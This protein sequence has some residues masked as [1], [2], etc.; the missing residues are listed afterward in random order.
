E[1]LKLQNKLLSNEEKDFNKEEVNENV[2]QTKDSGID[3]VTYSPLFQFSENSDFLSQVESFSENL[4]NSNVN[5]FNDYTSFVT[6]IEKFNKKDDENLIEKI[7]I[8]SEVDKNLLKL[9]IDL[10]NLNFLS[11]LKHKNFLDLVNYLIIS[12]KTTTSYSKDLEDKI[13]IILVQFMFEL[14][15]LN[16]PPRRIHESLILLIKNFNTKFVTNFLIPLIELYNSFDKKFPVTNSTDSKELQSNNIIL[17]KFIL[18]INFFE[19][20]INLITKSDLSFY[21]KCILL[22]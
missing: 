8:L 16:N 5:F 20:F 17:T 14:E 11:K 9:H 22:G 13:W 10:L 18:D 6:V 2:S 1:F 4:D 12:K 21:S 3:E 15:Q 19:F 7:G